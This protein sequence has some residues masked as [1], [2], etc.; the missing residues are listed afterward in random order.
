MYV[1]K[2]I[3]QDSIE[4]LVGRI[5][6]TNYIYF[7]DDELDQEGTSH[8]NPLYITVKYKGCVIAKV[9]IKN[10]LVLN[11]LLR[12]VLDKMPMDASHMKLST[13]TARAYD[14]LSRQIIGNINIKLLIGP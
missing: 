3:T 5:H 6:A 14:G 10:D 12:H 8:N 11:V 7:T 4:H 2:D 13:M 1:P 9:L